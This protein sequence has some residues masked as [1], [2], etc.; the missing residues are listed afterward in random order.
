[1][2]IFDRNK[3]K[4]FAELRHESQK[5]NCVIDHTEIVPHGIYS[6]IKHEYSFKTISNAELREY[7]FIGTL[8]DEKIEKP[9]YFE[10]NNYS[11]E[12]WS[13]ESK[14][15]TNFYPYNICKLYECKHCKKLFLVYTEHGGHG[16]DQRVRLVKPELIVEEPSNCIVKISSEKIPIILEILE[17]DVDNFY[18][19]VEKN[20]KSERV[21]TNFDL[22]KPLI[23]S[24]FEEYY[25]IVA[26]KDVI[27]EI[28]DKF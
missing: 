27:Y 7:N 12:Y 6:N 26:K 3:F 16:P 9:C 23:H 25:L 8:R 2:Q 21:N 5:I 10:F 15:A 24:Q 1:M 20:K 4:L 28:L 22:E 14:I 18:Q 17:I 11:G 19:I 13:T